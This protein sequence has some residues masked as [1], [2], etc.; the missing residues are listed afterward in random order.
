MT[1]TVLADEEIKA[2][3]HP[4]AVAGSTTGRTAWGWRDAEIGGV[5][6]QQDYRISLEQTKSI[7]PALI[8]LAVFY[9]LRRCWPV[10][11]ICADGSP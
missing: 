7:S 11:A 5:L 2:Q 9:G 3:E 6:I 4:G 1:M 10:S 8:G